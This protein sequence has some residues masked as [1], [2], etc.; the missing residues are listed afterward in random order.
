MNYS[1]KETIVVDGETYFHYSYGG[2]WNAT[3]FIKIWGIHYY[4]SDIP[5]IIFGPLIKLKKLNLNQHN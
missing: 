1:E 2:K 3:K 4:N 5:L